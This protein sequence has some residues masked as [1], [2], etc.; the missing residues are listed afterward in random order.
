MKSYD[1]SHRKGVLEIDWLKFAE[2]SAQLAEK[3]A[4]FQ[5]ETIIGVARAGLL[6]ATTV[7]CMLRCEFYPVRI[8]RR[9]NDRAVYPQPV[10]KTPVPDEVAGRRV[11]VIDEIA[12]TGETLALVVAGVQAKGAARVVTACLVSHTWARPQPDMVALR[13]DAFVIFP[14]DRQVFSD[15]QWQLHPEILSGLKTQE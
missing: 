11:A 5:P 6:P 9:V 13:S 7:A 2:L 1:Y 4:P 15:G 10:W 8:T 3:V 12:D 14:W